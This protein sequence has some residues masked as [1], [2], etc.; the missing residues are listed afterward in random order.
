M[1]FIEKFI[2]SK[3]EQRNEE[4][5]G[6]SL[7]SLLLVILVDFDMELL[8]LHRRSTPVN[9]SSSHLNL[10]QGVQNHSM[11]LNKTICTAFP[12]DTCWLKI[13]IQSQRLVQI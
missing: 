2:G 11:P 9:L 5:P 13:R 7:V 6:A 3:T 1:D 8:R 12:G 10:T 4:E